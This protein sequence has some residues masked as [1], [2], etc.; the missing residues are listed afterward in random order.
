[1]SPETV[2]GSSVPC[3]VVIRHPKERKSKCSLQPLVG[4]EDIIFHEARPGFQFDAT[5]YILLQVDAPVLSE[6]DAGLPL[7]LLD[8]TWRLLPQL[9]A[10]LTGVPTPRSLP[11]WLK[12]AYPRVSKIV[13]DP[14]PGLASV[15]A[16]Y[17]AR[18]LA[19]RPVDGLLDHYY[20]KAPFLQQFLQ[21]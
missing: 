18:L 7:L 11:A 17:A 14:A 20:W 2:S 16:L 1:M 5:G 12:T 8:S 3:D 10:S 19:G 21:M 6:A 9:V 15:E 4:R 13:Q